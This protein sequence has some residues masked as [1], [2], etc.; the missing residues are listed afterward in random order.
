MEEASD[1]LATS[2]E[3]AHESPSLPYAGR[4]RRIAA[5]LLDTA[6]AMTVIVFF[7]G[8][9]ARAVLFGSLGENGPQTVG[10]DFVSMWN[11][12]EASWKTMW[13]V[14]MLISTGPLYFAIMESSPWQATFGKRWLGIYVTDDKCQ[15]INTAL[16]LW[17]SFVKAI[18]PALLQLIPFLASKR[19]K[20]IH[21]FAAQT[22][23]LTGRT[24]HQIEIWR[25]L[26]ALGL[27][28]AWIV[29]T[30]L[31]PLLFDPLPEAEAGRASPVH[32]PDRIVCST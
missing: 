21:D 10:F 11:A 24:E 32:E 8:W 15:R 28:I 20:G 7:S 19:R 27:S 4:L 1:P 26:V 23:V 5:Y 22:L 29:L 18:F 12:M 6:L 31:G 13:A 30:F 17:R 16:S 9:I 14:A 2:R 25:P 3:A